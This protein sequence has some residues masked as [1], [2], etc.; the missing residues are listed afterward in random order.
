MTYSLP[1]EKMAKCG[2]RRKLRQS[3]LAV[4]SLSA[5]MIKH[6]GMRNMHIV[7]VAADSTTSILTAVVW[8]VFVKTELTG[9]L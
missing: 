2:L 5:A 1:K 8:V 9:S 3:I 6:P 7:R 4:L